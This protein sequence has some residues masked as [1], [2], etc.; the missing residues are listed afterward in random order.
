MPS[1]LSRFGGAILAFVASL[2]WS[3]LALVSSRA[4]G[5]AERS[6]R[7]GAATAL[8]SP[9]FSK[10]AAGHV[11]SHVYAKSSRMLATT[12]SARAVSNARTFRL[13]FAYAI[14]RTSLA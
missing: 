4:G 9:R 14:T 13:L 10:V 2:L 1:S 3:I 11:G 8:P 6:K 12:A 5:G 7:V